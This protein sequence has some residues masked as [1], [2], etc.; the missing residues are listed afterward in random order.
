M[1]VLPRSF[2]L[3]DTV[4]VSRD[5]LGKM[6]VHDMDGNIRSGIIIET[7]A[8]GSGNDPASHAFG[9]MTRRNQAMFGEVGRAYVYFTY[10]MHYCVNAV[11]RHA[12]SQAGAVL[13]RALRP[14][15]GLE[16]MARCRGSGAKRS[17]TGGPAMLTQALGITKKQYGEDLTTPEGLYICEYEAAGDILAGPRVG[18]RRGMD[19]N[20][21]FVLR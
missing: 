19:L 12:D 18:I 11:A 4:K 17:M 15:M 3:R 6:L 1:R 14:V 9:G 2:Y 10:G 5:L 8:Y 21:N 16:E 20:W 13:I 7:E